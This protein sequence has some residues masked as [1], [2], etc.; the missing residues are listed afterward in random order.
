[1]SLKEKFQIPTA[2][3]LRFFKWS[4]LGIL[5]GA[6]GG[7]LGAV[8]HHALHF[9]T[10]V[11]SEVNRLIFLLPVGGLLTVGLYRLFRQQ[12]KPGHKPDHRCGFKRQ[13]SQPFGSAADLPCHLC[14]PFVW[15]LCRSGRRSPSAGWCNC[16]P[17]G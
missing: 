17:T 9:V 11:R 7:V 6:L 14:N 13:R 15:R 5:M 8:F 10:H 2:Y 16:L 3:L 4:L 1:M 12:K